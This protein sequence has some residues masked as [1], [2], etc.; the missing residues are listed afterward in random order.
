MTLARGLVVRL[1]GLLFRALIV[2]V[3]RASEMDAILD[4]LDG[5]GNE[6]LSQ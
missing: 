2:V 1:Y 5:G 6:R 3:P 4:I